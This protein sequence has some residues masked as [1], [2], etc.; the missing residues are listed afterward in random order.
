MSKEK[1]DCEFIVQMALY[2]QKRK[3]NFKIMDNETRNNTRRNE[4][5][6]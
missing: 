3:P 5:E 2:D 4:N 1:F 6:K